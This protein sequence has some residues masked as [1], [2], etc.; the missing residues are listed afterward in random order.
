MEKN[1]ITINDI[2]YNI[3]EIEGLI[4]KNLINGASKSRDGFHTMT[5]GTWDDEHQQVALRT[6]VL[7]K[8]DEAKKTLFFH[9]DTRSRKYHHLKKN[10]KISIMLYDSH[11]RMQLTVS[12]VVDIHTDDEL[13]QQRWVATNPQSRRCYMTI[14]APHEEVDYPSIGYD[15]KFSKED[16]TEAESN[17][18][19]EN[20]CVVECKVTSIEW[21]FLHH[22]GN[23]KAMFHYTDGKF[24]KAQ[25]H[26]A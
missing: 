7:R 9:T 22:T 3:N 15:E 4:W 11:R 25:W 21:L 1:T 13:A 6:V 5:I 20:F 10:P 17:P 19:R 16:P 24:T 8:S 12:A 14:S 2:P 18:F 26:V 23:R